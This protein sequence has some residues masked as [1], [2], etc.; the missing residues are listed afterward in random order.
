[1][2]ISMDLLL[3]RT[4]AAQASYFHHAL[5]SVSYYFMTAFTALVAFCLY[6]NLSLAS[7]CIV[8]T[9][10]SSKN[11]DYWLPLPSL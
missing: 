1:M 10:A 3:D 11:I 5:T 6:S 9:F 8:L 2:T 7:T 4:L